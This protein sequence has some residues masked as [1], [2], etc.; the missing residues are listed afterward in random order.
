MAPE[1]IPC[2]ATVSPASRGQ[3][4]PHQRSV[5]VSVSSF[6][7]LFIHPPEGLPGKPV[8]SW[9]P[10][11]KDGMWTETGFGTSQTYNQVIHTSE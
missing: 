5:L 2:L 1:P 8:V 10:S 6:T 3:E 11:I 9:T 7:H 4:M